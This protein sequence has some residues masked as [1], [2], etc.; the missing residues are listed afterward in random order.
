MSIGFHKTVP[1]H[2]TRFHNMFSQPVFITRTVFWAGPDLHIISLIAQML[3]GLA[4]LAIVYYVE[5]VKLC[6][7][8]EIVTRPCDVDLAKQ[9]GNFCNNLFIYLPLRSSLDDSERVLT[10]VFR[11]QFF[12]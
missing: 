6:R 12:V 5:L 4:K 2:N 10:C 7:E 11:I 3:P 8:V 1:F 9:S